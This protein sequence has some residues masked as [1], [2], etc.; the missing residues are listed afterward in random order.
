MHVN[1]MTMCVQ[2][3]IVCVYDV[4]MKLLMVKNIAFCNVADDMNNVI[5]VTILE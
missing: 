2:N 3:E 4:I 1:V 5:R